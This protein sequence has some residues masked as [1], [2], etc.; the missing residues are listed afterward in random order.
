MLVFF[1]L[2]DVVVE[3]FLEAALEEFTIGCI[4]Q[5]QWHPD[6]MSNRVALFVAVK[7]VEASIQ[8]DF[9]NL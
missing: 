6:C 5:Q 2:T 8:I 3:C 7:K 9:K 1:P 4:D